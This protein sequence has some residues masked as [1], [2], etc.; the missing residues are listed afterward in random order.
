MGLSDE[1]IAILG[2]GQVGR[3]LHAALAYR[4]G[5][6][7]ALLG[8]QEADVTNYEELRNRLEKVRPT[9]VFNAAAYTR[10][11]DCERDPDTAE[12]V[13]TTGAWNV[14]AA[15]QELG[16]K[17]VYFSTDYVFPGRLLGD[18]SE[19]EAPEPLNV[20]GRT[21]LGGEKMTLEYSRGIVVR[22]SQV[23]APAG[24]NFLCAVHETLRSK[25]EATVVDDEFAVPTYAPHLAEAVLR[26]VEA[27]ERGI[28][29][30]RGPR[31]LTY[32]DWARKFFELAGM[33]AHKLK[34]TLAREL[35]LPAKRPQRAVLGMRR[36][37]SL[38]LPPL[39]PLQE[40]M[41]DFVE[42]TK[43]KSS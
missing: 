25:G 8:H 29:H 30:V 37:L 5:V 27:A 23:F 41:R 17:L 33:P 11:N 21:K 10:V 1:T 38:G 6:R 19:E 14:M 32:Y 9:L 12:L 16:A 34:R 40:A 7:A 3:A 15:A 39:P 36:Y 4:N 13:N 22:T 18:Y 20:Y 2:S 42:K 28:Y 24:R 26:L 31:E 35:K 43:L